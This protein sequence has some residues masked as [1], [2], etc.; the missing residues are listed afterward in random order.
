MPREAVYRTLLDERAVLKWRVPDG[1]TGEVHTFEPRVG[2]RVHISLTYE[3]PQ[4]EGKTEA[5]TDTYHGRFVEL[6]PNERIVEVV[7]FDTGD[8]ALQGE[9]R[10]TISLSDADGGTEVVA[11]H[12]GLPAG[13]DESANEEGWRAGLEKLAALLEAR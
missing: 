10:I 5:Q 6:I 13:L 1:M 7:E 2:G 4:R 8:D 3:D 12:D 11:V 9:M